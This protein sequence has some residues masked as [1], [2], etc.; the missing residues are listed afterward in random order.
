MH[1]QRRGG[2]RIK[3][4]VVFRVFDNGFGFRYVIPKQDC[5]RS[6]NKDITLVISDEKQSLTLRVI[7]RH[8][9]FLTIPKLM[10]GSGERDLS[11]V[12]MGSVR[13]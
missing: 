1:L 10:K 4:D 11:Q 9:L 5:L 6:N 7:C 13:L 3:L 12:K 8:G 2:L